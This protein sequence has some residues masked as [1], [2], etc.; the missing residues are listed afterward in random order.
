M[1]SNATVRSDFKRKP[2]LPNCPDVRAWSGD[3]GHWCF[4]VSV[5]FWGAKSE[6]QG[7]ARHSCIPAWVALSQ[8][9]ELAPLGVLWMFGFAPLVLDL[10]NKGQSVASI[11]LSPV[12]VLSSVL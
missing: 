4:L 6:L 10:Q 5:A 2:E 9:G 11:C 1:Q 12:L 3:R 8:W 7:L